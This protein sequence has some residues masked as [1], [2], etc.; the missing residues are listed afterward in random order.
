MTI[1]I[2]MDILMNKV[3]VII[4]ISFRPRVYQKGSIVVTLVYQ[5]I[6]LSIYSL[7][8]ISD[9]VHYFFLIFRMKLGYLRVQN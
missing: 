7:L 1:D 9:T 6:C 5:P 2:T 8:N 3:F 4:A